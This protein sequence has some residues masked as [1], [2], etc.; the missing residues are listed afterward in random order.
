MEAN[1]FDE[2]T[3]AMLL[4]TQYVSQIASVAVLLVILHTMKRFMSKRRSRLP[5]SPP[6]L[7]IIGHLHL[8]KKSNHR[9]LRDLADK[10][11]PIMTVR[12][13]AVR[14]VIVSSSAMAKVILKTQDH[15]FG[16]RAQCTAL[17]I[18]FGYQNS[19]VVMGAMGERWRFL[20][21]ICAQELFS[22][23]RVELSTVWTFYL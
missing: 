5:P 18:L 15:V 14:A 9:A 3:M 12:L 2:R 22:P 13:G 23:K 10:Y 4:P 11:G 21:K 6:G 7:P 17:G 19:D 1:D 16:S 20:R 8:T